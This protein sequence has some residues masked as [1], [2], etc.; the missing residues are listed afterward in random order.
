MTVHSRTALDRIEAALT[1]AASPYL[2]FSGGK[3]SLV[4]AHLARQVLPD[5]PLIYCDDELLWTE[6]VAY[7]EQM[8]G[9]FGPPFWHVSGG[10]IHAGW[11]RPWRE[12]PYWRETPADMQWLGGKGQF[13]KLARGLGYD[14]AIRG[15]RADESRG[16]AERMAETQ[17]SG[18][19]CGVR[20]C[21]PIYD[22]TADQV[23]T[24]IDQHALPVCPVYAR[25]TEI[26]VSRRLQRVGPLA[27]C[28]G[29]YLWR[30]WPELYLRLVRR[31]GARWTQPSRSDLRRMDPLLRLDLEGALR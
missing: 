20:T 13:S 2:A 18:W 30:G 23:W 12:P 17:G 24:Y 11:H 31:Y 28:P 4:V 7:V 6:H 10:S 14:L 19:R 27:L 9:F 21:D 25:L 16:R 3:D 29:K 26:G 8:K 1:G 22:W 5:L 15:L